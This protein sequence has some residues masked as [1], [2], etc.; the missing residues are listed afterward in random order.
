MPPLKVSSADA[1]KGTQNVVIGAFSVGFI[2]QSIDNSKA[3]GG[4]IGAF[5]GATR[6]K[7]VLAGVTPETMQAITDAAYE[8]F[9]AQLTGQGFTVGDS[10][11]M[12]ADPA[13]QKVKT[14]VVPYDAN[15]QLDKKSTGKATYFKP[16][17]LPGMML[18]AGTS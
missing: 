9:K 5:G 1:A 2:F 13:F 3:T 10:A 14:M 8:D 7:S 16:T 6:A 11:A 17:A 18:L 15:V 12:F 4:M